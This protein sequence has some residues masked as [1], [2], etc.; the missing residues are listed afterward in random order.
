MLTNK[1]SSTADVETLERRIVELLGM[2]DRWGQP[3][4]PL[5]NMEEINEVEYWAHR[6][7]YAFQAEAWF[8]QM[9]IADRDPSP[10]NIFG[11]PHWANLLVYLDDRG[12]DASGG[13]A[14]LYTYNHSNYNTA[15]GE[16]RRLIGQASWNEEHQPIRYFKW[17]QCKHDYH[18]TG[19]VER[20]SRG[21]HVYT[22]SKCNN[23][24]TVDSGD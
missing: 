20:R 17:T 5:P 23:Q 24:Y 15:Y 9:K 22:C 18:E 14:V 13:Y 12:K 7:S 3:A 21:W 16:N 1:V 2:K 10:K 19:P 8:S 11:H 6:F 4:W